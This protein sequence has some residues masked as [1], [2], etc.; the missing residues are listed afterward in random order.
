MI[1]N[2]RMYS[3]TPQVAALWRSLLG[4]IL[5]DTAAAIEIVDHHADGTDVDGEPLVERVA[6]SIPLR[7]NAY[8]RCEP[9]A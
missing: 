2:A 8:P 7:V 9:R 6:G 1:A 4:A 3:V 5:S